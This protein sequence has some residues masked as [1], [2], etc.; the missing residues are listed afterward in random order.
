MVINGVS[1]AL[2]GLLHAFDKNEYKVDLFLRDHVG[3]FLKY[4]P[5]AVALLPENKAYKYVDKT[6]SETLKC[7]LIPQ[8]FGKA[9]GMMKAKRYAKKHGCQLS[10]IALDYTHR[11][12]LPFLPMIS[13][14][15]YD[16]VISF[17]APHYFGAYR[18]KAKKRLS[19]IHTDYSLIDIDAKSEEKVWGRYDGIASISDA[20]GEAFAAK[21]PTVKDKIVRI[22]NP[23][24]PE[25]IRFSALDGQNE[26]TKEG[27]RILSCGTLAP[28][29]N[30]RS[31]STVFVL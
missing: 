30:F 21:I 12:Q 22:D 26:M 8:A 23:I 18:C 16:L 13:K 28:G 11:H 5:A 14:E 20:S 15:E 3:E 24:S 17:S 9:L 27:I 6:T 25:L 7:G 10:A 1:R 2:I 31:I 4:V 29:K 19:W